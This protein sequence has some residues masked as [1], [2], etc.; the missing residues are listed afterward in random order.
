M[1]AVLRNN[2]GMSLVEVVGALGIIMVGLLA[3]IAAVPLST[4]LIGQSNLKTTA[5]FLAQQRMER[6]KN[7]Q[8]TAAPT[9]DCLG[10]AG[11]NGTSAVSVTA[12]NCPPPVAD[13]VNPGR[14]PDEAYNTI[15]ITT[16]ETT[17]SYPRFRRQVRIIDCLIAICSGIPT[18][19]TSVNTVRQVTV[20][21]FFRPQS[22]VGTTSADEESLQLVSLIARR[23]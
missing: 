2:A 1:I 3:L 5:T 13:L 15:L 4:S 8:W 7:A 17:A 20:T 6:I 21:V 9:V 12:A 19:T 18:G 22:G 10:G 23:P 11:S 14:W 16:G